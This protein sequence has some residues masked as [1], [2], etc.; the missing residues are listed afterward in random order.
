[1]EIQPYWSV[2]STQGWARCGVKQVVQL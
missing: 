1:V 2:D